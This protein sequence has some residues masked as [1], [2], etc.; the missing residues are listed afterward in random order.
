VKG[1]GVQVVFL[2]VLQLE[3]GSWQK[4]EQTRHVEDG[5][6]TCKTASS[7]SPRADRVK[8]LVDGS[9]E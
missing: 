1:S 8:H 6:V 2:S 7:A 5:E 3:T 9:V 4:G